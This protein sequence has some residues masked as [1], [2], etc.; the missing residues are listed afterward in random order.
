MALPGKAAIYNLT[1]TAA[2]TEYSQ[3]LPNNAFKYLVKCR[4]SDPLKLAFAA[5]QSGSLYVTVSAGYSYWE[6]GINT[7]QTLYLQSPT[8]GAV[9]EIIAW[10]GA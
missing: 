3:A 1:L 5:G 2:N 10:T 8:A 6:D 4:T 7:V 9:A